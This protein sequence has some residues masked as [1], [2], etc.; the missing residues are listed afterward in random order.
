MVA[1][2]QR[3][4]SFSDVALVVLFAIL[5]SSI[6]RTV[7]RAAERNFISP[8]NKVAIET[9]VG[10][11]SWSIELASDDQSRATG[12]MNRQK[13]PAF[14]GMLFRFRETRPVSMWMKNTFISL[15]MVFTDSTGRIK[16]IQ[17]ATV[18]QSLEI[19]RSKG[20]V[21]YVLEI[22]AGEASASGMQ[23]GN[24]FSHPWF[25]DGN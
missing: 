8:L 14:S 11:F 6:S 19:I 4:I 23:V 22:N 1:N 15:D 16:N 17:Y 21:R 12:L 13:M 10:L 7:V 3:H 25:A 20:P 2:S 9:S 18:P 24:K 5:V